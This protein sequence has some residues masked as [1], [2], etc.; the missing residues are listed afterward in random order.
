M[1]S[2]WCFGV[3]AVFNIGVVATFTIEVVKLDELNW[4]GWPPKSLL[5]EISEQNYWINYFVKF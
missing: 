4:E 5:S 2:E 3:A 1:W